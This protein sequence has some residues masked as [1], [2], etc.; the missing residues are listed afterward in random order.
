MKLK[1]WCLCI[2]VSALMLA[3]IVMVMMG[4]QAVVVDTGRQILGK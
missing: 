1:D 3:V 2:G 4:V